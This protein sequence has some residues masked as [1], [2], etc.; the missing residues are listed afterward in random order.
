M[1]V[2]H[3]SIGK[4]KETTVKTFLGLLIMFLVPLLF[5]WFPAIGLI[6]GAFGGYLI[7]R[8]VKSVLLALAPFCALAL[9]VAVGGLGL[10]IPLV[11]AA[12]AGVAFVW[13]AV[14]SVLLLAGAFVGG[15]YYTL[16]HGSGRNRAYL[17]G[18]RS[19]LLH[20]GSL[21]RWS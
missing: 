18:Y 8:P 7:G 5:F 2:G 4:V 20:D 15:L 6:A 9:L 13:L 17:P 16:R 11:G 14:H 19:G 21:D 1:T 3:S 12:L 10:G